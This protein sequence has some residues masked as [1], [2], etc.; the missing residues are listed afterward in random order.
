MQVCGNTPMKKNRMRQENDK[1]NV[2]ARREAIFP[3]NKVMHH[4]YTSCLDA[5]AQAL[6]MTSSDDVSSTRLSAR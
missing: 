5:H 6:F 1:R 3:Q 2:G 4:Q